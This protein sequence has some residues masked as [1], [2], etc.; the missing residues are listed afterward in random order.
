MRAFAIVVAAVV[1]LTTTSLS[2][3]ASH[4]SSPPTTA[5]GY[6][7][8][9]PLAGARSGHF[10]LRPISFPAANGAAVS[11]SPTGTPGTGTPVPTDTAIPVD[12]NTPTPTVTPTGPAVPDGTTVLQNFALVYSQIQT[13]HVELITT[14]E[15]PSVEK[16]T[17]DGIG[18]ATCKGPA[19][20]LA[21]KATDA[22]EGTTQSRTSK[23]TYIQSKN[24]T[25]VK[26][27]AKKAKWTKVKNQENV[28]FYGFPYPIDNPLACSAPA[29]S[30]TTTPTCTD[31]S[32]DVSNLGADTFQG[33]PTW[34]IQ[35]TDV[36]TCTDG[37]T[38][39]FVDDFYIGQAHF[40]PYVL[41]QSLN[42]TQDGLII[43]EKQVTTKIGE[44]V[45]IKLHKFGTA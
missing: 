39:N 29:S 42:D 17:I 21:V 16:L 24:T 32:K 15:K 2:A 43:V 30:T 34:H 11:D 31:I 7:L 40:Q 27:S 38:L 10:V 26:T 19:M 25:E 36:R 45:K 1:L 44:K 28:T 37:T 18:D 23:A 41:S 6:T 14:A 12:T 8:L 13:A 33:H 20:Q 9:L 35:F 22:L 3:I 4:H 5:S